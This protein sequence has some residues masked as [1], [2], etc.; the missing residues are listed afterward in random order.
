MHTDLEDWF[1]PKLAEWIRNLICTEHEELEG[2]T[3]V[4]A[5]SVN[6]GPLHIELSYCGDKG[7]DDDEGGLVRVSLGKQ[8]IEHEWMCPSTDA[9]DAFSTTWQSKLLVDKEYR[10]VFDFEIDPV[11]KDECSALHR[12]LYDVLKGFGL[13][14][15]VYVKKRHLVD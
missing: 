3:L 15:H 4:T 14:A 9:L 8:S 7:G 13:N 5:L 12:I 6:I 11:H 10:T 1:T 2:I